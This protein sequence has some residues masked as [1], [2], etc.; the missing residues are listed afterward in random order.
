[1]TTED[2]NDHAAE[3]RKSQALIVRGGEE[4]E[5]DGQKS[6]IATPDGRRFSRG[7]TGTPLAAAGQAMGDL[8][9]GVWKV[10]ATI[11]RLAGA[12]D[13]AL[14]QGCRLAFRKTAALVTGILRFVWSAIADLV[15]W[16]PSRGGRA[17][18]AGSAVVLIITGLYIADDLRT[19]SV[20]PAKPGEIERPPIDNEDPILARID[21]RY[22]HLSDIV[23]HAAATGMLDK[24]QKLTVD[25]A[26]RRGLV[27]SFVEQRLLA[28]AARDAG[29]GRDGEVAQKLAAAR[30]R[31]LAA[32]FLDKR[33]EESVTSDRVERFYASQADIVRLG[34]EVRARHIVV[35]TEAEAAAIATELE[36]GGDFAAIAR[37]KSLDRA[38]AP[39]GGE[40]GYFT[41]DMMPPIIANA[42]FTT[43][44]GSLA[45]MFFGEAGWHILEV[46]DRRPASGVSYA[47]VSDRIR[48][49]L[50]LQTVNNILTE[51]KEREEVVYYDPKGATQRGASAPASRESSR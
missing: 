30:E 17:Y 29:I 23:A 42:A 47:A 41:E 13:S 43:P 36:A 28:R 44:V 10:I 12:L 19:P 35:A 9:R 38:T 34:D 20:S 32:A 7:A 33:I 37:E 46:R 3:E 39:L 16:L 8:L 31:I 4:A 48:E 5:K 45:P 50:T 25:A 49:F 15:R 14:W 26:C 51:L 18:A 24:G 40:L 11:W 22:I 1:V 21:G 6:Q 27:E 2:R